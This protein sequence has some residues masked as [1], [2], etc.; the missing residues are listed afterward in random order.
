MD[1]TIT[2]KTLADGPKPALLGMPSAQKDK[3]AE[4]TPAGENSGTG[5]KRRQSI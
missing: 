4:K 2:E 5:K 3:E 1:G